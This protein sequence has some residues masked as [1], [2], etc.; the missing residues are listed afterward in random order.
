MGAEIMADKIIDA[1]A[2]YE[3][4]RKMFADHDPKAENAWQKFLTTP[5]WTLVCVSLYGIDK[6]M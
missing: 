4:I 5:A 1:K 6:L 3:R 2:E